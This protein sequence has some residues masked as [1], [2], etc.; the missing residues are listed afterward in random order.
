MRFERRAGT[1]GLAGHLRR[2]LSAVPGLAGRDLRA[3]PG[4]DANWFYRTYMD[5][6]E[7]GF[8]TLSS[9]LTLGL[10]VPE[11]AVLLD[12]L[13]LGRACPTRRCRSCR[14]RC[15][16]VVGVFE[17]LTGSPAWRHFEQF[18]ADAYEGRAEV[19]LV[20][21]SIAQVGNYDYMIDWIFTQN[22]AIRVEVGLT[23]I[24]AAEGGAARRASA[25]TCARSARRWRRSSSRREPQPSLQLPARSR[26]R[27]SAEQLSCWASSRSARRVGRARACG[28]STSSSI[29]SEREGRLDHDHAVWKVINLT[30][31][32]T[33]S[34]RPVGYH[35]CSRTAA[36][37]RCSTRP[38]TSAPVHRTPRCGSPRTDLDERYAAGDTPNQNPGAPGL[39]QYVRNNQSLVNRDIVAL[40]D[41]RLSPRDRRPRTGRCC[42]ARR[43]SFELKPSNFFD[44]NPALG[45]CGR[46][47][48]EVR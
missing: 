45:F 23:G 21:R 29:A 38:T 4:P 1:G 13:D 17:R 9:P 36:S 3:L 39:P 44:R 41:G 30:V 24:D 33:R 18:A 22:G 2:A 43:L 47:P 10:D 34:A 14:C 5:A 25:R 8:G 26:R 19:E 31:A 20:V 40:A 35:H 42:R 7:F 15:R 28:R 27:W 12:A 46:A 48:P 37:S 32:A 16:E 11:N 6:G